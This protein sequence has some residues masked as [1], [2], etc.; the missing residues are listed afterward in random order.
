MC[1]FSLLLYRNKIS[2][3]LIGVAFC[4]R[5]YICKSVVQKILLRH[6]I[7]LYSIFSFKIFSIQSTEGNITES[8][9]YFIKKN[10]DYLLCFCLLDILSLIPRLAAFHLG[11]S[12][13]LK[14]TEYNGQHMLDSGHVYQIPCLFPDTSTNI[15]VK[16]YL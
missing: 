5:V 7:Y 16:L 2:G 6:H 12:L 8:Y 1:L 4:S 10:D 14:H 15:I 3:L 9:T 13:L 11:L